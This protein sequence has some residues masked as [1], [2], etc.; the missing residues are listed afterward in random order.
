MDINSPSNICTVYDT[1]DFSKFILTH[2]ESLQGGSF[3]TKLN[4]NND[5]LYVQTPK[6]ISKQVCRSVKVS[7]LTNQFLK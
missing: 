7:V 3:F 6:C 5:A 1:F 2:P 4:V